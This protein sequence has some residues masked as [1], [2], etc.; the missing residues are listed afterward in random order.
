MNPTDPSK[1]VL[2]QRLRARRAAIVPAE[3]AS[4]SRAITDLLEPIVDA[5]DVIAGFASFQNEVDLTDLYR[6]ILASKKRLS[7][8]RVVGPGEMV[9]VSVQNLDELSPGAFGIPE[10]TG[11]AHPCEEIEVFLIPGL[12]FDRAGNRLGFGGGFY[13]RALADLRVGSQKVPLLIGIGYSWQLL[14]SFLPAESWDV[15]LDCVVTDE[16]MFTFDAGEEPQETSE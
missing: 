9:F 2:R 12:A 5:H 11:F 16:G 13:D 15:R 6:L 8:P 3:Q 10:P 4:A 7:F 1:D 14:D